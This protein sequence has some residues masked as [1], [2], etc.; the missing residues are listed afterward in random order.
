MLKN[1]MSQLCLCMCLLGDF[2]IFPIDVNPAP[3]P[4]S[5][6]PSSF[7]ACMLPEGTVESLQADA[8][9]NEFKKYFLLEQPVVHTHKE[10]HFTW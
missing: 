5:P 1:R 3:P 4:P 8:V 7:D 10:W 6:C 9:W 2:D